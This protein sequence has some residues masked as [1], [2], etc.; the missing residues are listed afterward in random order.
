MP[1]A[2]LPCQ[3]D[4]LQ[5]GIWIGKTEEKIGAALRFEGGA[6]EGKKKEV[7]KICDAAQLLS[8]ENA[9]PLAFC[10]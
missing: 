3:G 8:Q 4:S 9:V 1:Q 2:P 10:L 5:R 7:K 6:G